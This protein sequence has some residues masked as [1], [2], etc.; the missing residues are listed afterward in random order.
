MTKVLNYNKIPRIYQS[1]GSQVQDS[2]RWAGSEDSCDVKY[3]V[4]LHYF[5]LTLLSLL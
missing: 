5:F 3:T 1:D 4:A 2:N